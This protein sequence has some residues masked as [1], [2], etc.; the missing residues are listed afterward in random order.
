MPPNVLHRNHF[1]F[2]ATRLQTLRLLD[3]SIV[4][5]MDYQLI[6]A[7]APPQM[8]RIAGSAAAAH[9]AASR[10]RTMAAE[11]TLNC[12]H[13]L[14]SG[15]IPRRPWEKI[16]IDI[17]ALAQPAPDGSRCM[18][19]VEDRYTH[20]KMKFPVRDSTSE[21]IVQCL[22]QKVF[23]RYGLPQNIGGID[24]SPQLV[25]EVAQKIHELTKVNLLHAIP[26]HHPQESRR[27]AVLEKEDVDSSDSCDR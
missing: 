6:P 1:S 2:R 21:S 24:G 16:R 12:S 8:V 18:L 5:V 7:S 26:P 15:S 27:S 10:I 22:L 17:Y 13:T 20:V 14:E 4:D 3:K 25:L 9:D 11:P 23:S 19:E